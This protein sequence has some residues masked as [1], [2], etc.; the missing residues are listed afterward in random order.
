MTTTT[1]TTATP[2]LRWLL[3]FNGTAPR[4]WVRVEFLRQEG[5]FVI[6][7]DA[8][9]GEFPVLPAALYVRNPWTKERA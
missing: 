6:V 7:R 8:E 4:T 3:R 5:G 2:R 9:R 1:T